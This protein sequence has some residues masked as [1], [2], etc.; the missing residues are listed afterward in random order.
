MKRKSQL[1][2]LAALVAQLPHPSLADPAAPDDLSEVVVTGIR[3][4]L[5][6][7]QDIKRDADSVV[8]AITPEDLGHFTDESLADALERVPGVQVA[9]NASHIYESGSGVT[10]RGLGADFVVTTLDG[11][12]VLG[13][14]AFGGGS[15]R[16]VD[17]DA[18]PPEVTS[19]LVVYKSPTASLIESGIAGEINIQTLEPLA[20]KTNGARY[21][22]SVTA[23]GDY[24]SE[25]ARVGPRFS[26]LLGGKLLDDTLGFYLAGVS[27]REYQDEKQVLSY[28]GPAN[29]NIQQ[30]DGTTQAY[31]G[32]LTEQ[33]TD[34]LY[35]HYNF[36]RSNLTGAIQWRP[37]ERLDF[38][39]N[40]MYNEYKSLLNQ[41]TYQNYTGYSLP[42][43]TFAPGGAVV[44][45][46]ALVSYDT[47]AAVGG[48]PNGGA[49]GA[50]VGGIVDT[51]NK[52]WL[53]GFK[54]TYKG[55]SWRA[56]VDYAHNEL[57]YQVDL[58]NGYWI[59][60]VAR[61]DAI[62]GRYDY[63]GKTYGASYYGANTP[64]NLALYNPA[65]GPSNQLNSYHEQ[66]YTHSTRDQFRVDAD[67]TP[68]DWLTLKTGARREQTTVWYVDAV[69]NN[70]YTLFATPGDPTS[71]YYTTQGFLSGARVN[72][73][74]VPGMPTATY[75]GFAA[76][77]PAVTSLSDFGRGSFARFPSSPN[78]SPADELP[79]L[80]GNSYS[81][82]E[83]T[84]AFYVQGEGEGTVWGLDAAANA[85]VRALHV[86]E[87]THGF[88]SVGTT[89]S[90]TGNQLISQTAQAV[91][92]NNSYWRALPAAN[93]RVSPFKR[94]NL[95]LSYAKTL[96]L[97]GLS[98][99]RP[100]GQVIYDLP[101]NNLQLPN[102]F[103]GG[104][105][106]L[107]P[108]MADNYDFTT[109]YYTPWGGAVVA[110]L[111]YKNVSDFVTTLTQL[112]V[113]VTGRS[114]LFNSTTSVNAGRG[115]T[116][117]FEIGTNQPFRFLPSPYDGFGV[118]ANYTYVDSHQTVPTSNGPVSSSLPGT[119]K[120]NFNS[121]VYF[122]KW[123]FGARV[124]YNYRSDYVLG[125]GSL[126]YNG[127]ITD[128]E[129]VAGYQTVDVSLS[130]KIGDH[131]E[132]L[133]TGTNLTRAVQTHYFGS[134]HL[135]GDIFPFPRVYTLSV[136]GKL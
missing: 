76:N 21:F 92:A 78:G 74:G 113:P 110:S 84:T 45:D 94:L 93:L 91:S 5:E 15:F 8:E 98:S 117:G 9:R 40:G 64:G 32:I 29:I 18:I 14:P 136:R 41:S 62:N 119:S 103:N 79:I 52:N 81:I 129:F 73:P 97:P 72:L 48:Y 30:A 80:S 133:L 95:R 4:S 66:Q 126:S 39:V 46:G 124:A 17:F 128:R 121:T 2:L 120:N 68:L 70:D 134:G 109:E 44:R 107:K 24:Q 96:T 43:V 89:L 63:S 31:N 6:K 135:F 123:G 108:T 116:S 90:N 34:S 55:D 111:F 10:I 106:Y 27:S 99:L 25:A 71:G 56:V 53:I 86:E 20:Y 85:G 19:G 3:A 105:S 35:E 28:A 23:Q 58:A 57:G 38:K 12:D 122:E 87:D 61:A 47:S 125:V 130:Q 127:A 75:A 22:G 13:N 104:N 59:S 115:R 42:G 82:A 114:G 36:Q 1:T 7:A 88:Q 77:N 60:S 37:S 16:S 49:N 51:V 50:L 102:S 33:E 101:Y 112:E 118:S 26:G 69:G 100:N 83:K 131:L 54:G 11:R 67:W 132:I 65:A